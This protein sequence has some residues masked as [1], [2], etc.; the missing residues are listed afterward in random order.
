VLADFFLIVIAVTRAYATLITIFIVI[1]FLVIFITV[2]IGLD[3]VGIVKTLKRSRMRWYG[4][5]ES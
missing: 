1:I 2:V 3:I 4:S 5:F